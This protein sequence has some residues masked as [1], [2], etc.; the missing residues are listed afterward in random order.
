MKYHF[1][2][3]PESGAIIIFLKVDNKYNYMMLLDTGATH[4]TIDS[5]A[6]Y[7]DEY[8]L[9]RSLG[10]AETETSN[11]IIK[12]DIF[13]LNKIASLGVVREPFQIQVYDFL[14]QG[15]FSNYDGVL[16]LDFFENTEFHI[17]MKQCTI[18]V[19]DLAVLSI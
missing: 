8:N 5:S 18:E 9:E 14:S 2:R 15:I 17:N 10:T 16:G 7:L 4:T 13:E 11:G 12:V 3:D 19:D 1:D 6:L